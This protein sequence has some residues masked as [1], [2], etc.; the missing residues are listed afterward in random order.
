MAI[1]TADMKALIASHSL[2]Y[3]ATVNAD[4]TPNLSPKATMVALD[5]TRIAFGD[6]RSPTTVANLKARPGMEI[7][8]IDVFARR[9]F[10]F[11]GTAT[12]ANRDSAEFRELLPHFSAWGDLADSFHGVIVLNVERA[13][14][15]SSPAYDHG[16]TEPELRAQWRQKYLDM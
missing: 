2:G 11:R 5:D 7:N 9:G 15:V 3:V 1:I 12:Y 16:A 14:P 6:L 10:R 8:F 13:L 4:G